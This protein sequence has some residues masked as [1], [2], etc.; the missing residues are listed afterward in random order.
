MDVLEL[1]TGSGLAVAA[2]L[3]AYIP[4][5]AL[6]LLSRFTDL[7]QLPGGWTWLE[8]PASLIILAIL[9]AIEVVADKIPAVDSVNDAIQ[10]VIRPAAGGMV[11][12]AGSGS[13]TIAIEDPATIFQTGAWVPIALGVFL[14]L[15]THT[16]K[17]IGRP[18]VNV[19]TAGAGGPVVSTAED[20]SSAALVGV[21]VF[22]PLLVALVLVVLIVGVIWLV[23]K[24]REHG[25]RPT[26]SSIY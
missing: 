10:T 20:V 3:N 4:L 11:F 18:I 12:A 7:V 5:L 26:S 15:T 24:W 13:Q 16:A 19:S 8:H 23:L 22:L 21:S 17:A 1:L 9:L 25:R 14:A 6:G 2:G